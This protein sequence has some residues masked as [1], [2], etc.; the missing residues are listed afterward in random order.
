MMQI[1]G[2]LAAAALVLRIFLVTQGVDRDVIYNLTP[3][4]I[5]ALA[6]GGF[7][8]LA[9]RGP[10]GINMIVPKAWIALLTSAALMLAVIGLRGTLGQ[11]NPALPTIVYSL[12]A[13][14]FGGLIII[15]MTWSPLKAVLNF[16]ML[17]WFGKYSYGLYIWH[18]IIGVII[19]HSRLAAAMHL[20][21]QSHLAVAMAMAGTFALSLLTAWLSYHLFEK[22]FL[23]LKRYFSN[24]V[25]AGKSLTPNSHPLIAANV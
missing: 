18:P 13:A 25:S 6:I 8:S 1:A 14:I 24:S 7:I 4:R 2:A 22:H 9:L 11:G 5:D 19:L 10:H 17:R 3:T 20:Q 23:D 21:E 15:G 16:G 12:L